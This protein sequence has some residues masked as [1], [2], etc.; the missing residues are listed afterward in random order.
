MLPSM[1]IKLMKLIRLGKVMNETYTLCAGSLAGFVLGV[2]FFGGLWWTTR[3]GLVSSQPALWFLGSLLVR[4]VV[5]MLGLYI[6]SDGDWRRL[7]ACL[8]GFIIARIAVLRMFS[9]TLF[10]GDTIVKAAEHGP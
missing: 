3:K 2:L 5:M 9:S 1:M 10:A 4:T 8:A 7:I 6:V